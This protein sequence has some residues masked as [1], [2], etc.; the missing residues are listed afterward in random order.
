MNDMNVAENKTHAWKKGASESDNLRKVNYN[1]A[2]EVHSSM[3]MLT[4]V[5]TSV[6]R[7]ESGEEMY[8]NRTTS[9]ADLR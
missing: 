7:L 5:T 1:F 2:G 3:Q 9:G 6:P 4:N 8:K